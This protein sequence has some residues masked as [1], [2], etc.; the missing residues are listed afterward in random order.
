MAETRDWLFASQQEQ[1]GAV[2]E[3][4]DYHQRVTIHPYPKTRDFRPVS[5]KRLSR[6]YLVSY[7]LK[8]RFFTT[9]D[10]RSHLM[11]IYFSQALC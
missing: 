6:V 11:R 9:S 3:A 5:R 4:F 8:D 7:P 10:H 2:A 1:V